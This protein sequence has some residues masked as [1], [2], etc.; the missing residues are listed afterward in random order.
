M[1]YRLS[2]TLMWGIWFIV[3]MIF[4]MAWVYSRKWLA[5]VAV[6]IALGNIVQ[7]WAFYRCPHCGYALMNVRGK[8]PEH[9]PECGEKLGK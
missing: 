9:C 8:M 3:L 7:S 4:A 6:V 5:V 1:N 2:R